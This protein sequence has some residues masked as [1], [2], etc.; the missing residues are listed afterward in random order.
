M[1]DLTR[2]K[3][4]VS[5][6]FRNLSRERIAIF[7]CIPISLVALLICAIMLLSLDKKAMQKP[8]VNN[9]V[10]EAAT[11]KITYS[12]ENPYSLEYESLGNGCCAIVGIGSFNGK[13]LKIPQTNSRGETVTEIAPKAFSDC[14]TL[15]SVF[16]PSTVEEIG[17]KAFRGCRSLIYIDVD[18]NNKS[19]T[20]IS[21][22]LFS[23]NR[24]RLIYYP[25]KRVGERYY[26]NANVRAIDDYA[27]EDAEDISVILYPNSTADFEAISIGKGN[28]ILHTLPITCNYTG[29]K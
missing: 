22:V 7:I 18:M 14:N 13:D 12:P 27:F 15:E 25:A 29:S 17:N 3:I 5:S 11:E 1:K 26:L 24:S 23:K 19:F 10:T 4:Y 21:G 2:I 8:N 20:S 6:Y 28:D 9:A 16:I